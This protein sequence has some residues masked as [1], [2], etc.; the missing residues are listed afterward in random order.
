MHI[1][2]I[3]SHTGDDPFIEFFSSKH[4]EIKKCLIVEALSSSLD[5]CKNTYEKKFTKDKGFQKAMAQID[6]ILDQ[7]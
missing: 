2:Q 4:E 5:I 1:I 7:I 6:Y 3:G